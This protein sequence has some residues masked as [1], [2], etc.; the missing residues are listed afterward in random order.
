MVTT[1]HLTKRKSQK[2]QN[3]SSTKTQGLEQDLSKAHNDVKKLTSQKLYLHRRMKK[4]GTKAFFSAMWKCNTRAA[5]RLWQQHHLHQGHVLAKT[6]KAR[7]WH[8]RRTLR[9]CFDGL[10]LAKRQ[11]LQVEVLF[12]RKRRVTK[13]NVYIQWW[14]YI[15][16]RRAAGFLLG[17]LMVQAKYRMCQPAFEHMKRQDVVQNGRALVEEMK[18]RT[19]AELKEMQTTVQGKVVYAMF[20]IIIQN[21]KASKSK[22]MR[23]WQNKTRYIVWEEQAHRRVATYLCSKRV[24]R[25]WLHWRDLL[26]RRALARNAIERACE[27]NAE[28]V[29]QVRLAQGFQCFYANYHFLAEKD[30]AAQ[31]LGYFIYRQAM[32]KCSV[33]LSKWTRHTHAIALQ[34]SLGYRVDRFAVTYTRKAKLRTFREWKY[35]ALEILKTRRFM[36]GRIGERQRKQQ[37]AVALTL[38]QRKGARNVIGAKAIEAVDRVLRQTILRL[39]RKGFSKF[40]MVTR[41]SKAIAQRLHNRSELKRFHVLNVC[42]EQWCV[43]VIGNR[44]NVRIAMKAANK[45]TY[46]FRKRCLLRWHAAAKEL[47]QTKVLLK[48][49]AAKM[50]HRQIHSCFEIWAEYTE[51]RQHA[52]KLAG[53]V[54]RRLV[55]GQMV[56]AWNK[57]YVFGGGCFC[58]CCFFSF[59]SRVS[60]VVLALL[61]LSNRCPLVLPCCRVLTPLFPLFQLPTGTK[62]F[63]SRVDTVTLSKVMPCGR[64]TKTK[65]VV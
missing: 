60:C 32:L 16:H 52:R 7:Q 14:D 63:T 4:M 11:A 5:F 54:F 40:A 48:R 57:W 34:M 49:A 20:R 39:R 13:R 31:V 61:S 22:A 18:Q 47:K 17:K 41:R 58:C 62:T 2:A 37:L 65:R 55:D 15:H 42:W 21:H 1:N 53:R 24:Q 19:H 3:V 35:V 8:Q 56:G 12:F 28:H 38:W 43:D 23:V 30:S 46:E 9:V 6:T 45:L 27:N 44:E 33:A 64:C 50:L 29:T 51:E 10:R 59:V 36:L 26:R 25:V